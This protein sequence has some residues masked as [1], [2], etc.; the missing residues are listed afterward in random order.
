MKRKHLPLVGLLAGGIFGCHKEADV[1]KT[2]AQAAA[3][4]KAI[5]VRAAA[6]QKIAAQNEA[7]IFTSF[8]KAGV[9]ALELSTDEALVNTIVRFAQMRKQRARGAAGSAYN[10]KEAA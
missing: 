7:D 4:Q 10:L 3:D 6:D 2:A 8:A 5:A 9:D 1:V